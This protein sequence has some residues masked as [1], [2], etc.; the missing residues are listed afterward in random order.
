ME[1]TYCKNR[2][3]GCKGEGA[4]SR[5]KVAIAFDGSKTWDEYIC[6]ECGLRFHIVHEEE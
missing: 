2:D 5:E 6:Q 4:L 1:I 3:D